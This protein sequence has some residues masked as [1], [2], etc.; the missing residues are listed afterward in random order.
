M[1]IRD[2]QLG[3]LLVKHIKEYQKMLDFTNREWPKDFAMQTFIDDRARS[4]ERDELPTTAMLNQFSDDEDE[5]SQGETE[6]EMNEEEQ[7]EKP[8]GEAEGSGTQE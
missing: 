2:S 8:A 7:M 1:C 5:T 4:G 6:K 3:N